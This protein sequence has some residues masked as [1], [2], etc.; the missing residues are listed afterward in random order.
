MESTLL[1]VAMILLYTLQSLLTKKYVDHYPGKEEM[2][3]SVFTIVSGG[4]VVFVSLCFMA[5]RFEASDSTLLLGVLNAA[6][7]I[8][9]NL[10]IVKTA[11]TGPY[12]V[13]MV[14]SIAGGIIIPTLFAYA[15]F[16]EPMSPWKWIV[17]VFVLLAV[18]MMSHKSKGEVAW[19]KGFI[20][21]C[22]GLALSNG[23]YGTVLNTQQ[24]L[25]GPGEKE[26]LIAL[27]YAIAA[28]ASLVI[29]FVKEKG[30]VSGF[31]QTR[32]S[33]FYL[34]LCSVVVALAINVLVCIIPL[35]NLTVLYTFDNAGT[36]LL[37]I[38]CSVV[39]FKE[40]LSRL[41]V[42]GCVLMCLSLIAISIV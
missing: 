5:F 26:E 21:A 8:A 38:I 6:I 4:V 14:F 34:A 2:A 25:T 35:V 11:Q 27:T 22:F 36:L 15:F 39:F 24:Q 13:L 17:V 29:F 20:P 18:Y 28:L 33:L 19:Q 12:T 40:K 10:F 37:S 16:G 32:R 1:I 41:N 3:S 23:A 9:Y 31:K 7:I 42:A 30:D